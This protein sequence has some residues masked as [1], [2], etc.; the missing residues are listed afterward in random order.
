[1]MKCIVASA[2]L[3]SWAVSVGQTGREQTGKATQQVCQL[4]SAN[5]PGFR[6]FAF[7]PSEIKDKSFKN[8]LPRISFVVGEDGKVGEVKLIKGTGSP[9]VDAAVVKSVKAWSYKPQAGCVISMSM[10]INIDVR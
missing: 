5:P 10:A 9:I 1:M 6:P 4:V 8:R 2:L 3:L 7:V